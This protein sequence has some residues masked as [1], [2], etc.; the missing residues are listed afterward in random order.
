MAIFNT[1]SLRKFAGIFLVFSLVGVFL[2][3]YFLKYIPLEEINFHHSSFLELKQFESALEERNNAYAK[4]IENFIQYRD[5]STLHGLHSRDSVDLTAIAKRFNYR[6][7]QNKPTPVFYVG[8][9]SLLKLHKISLKRDKLINKWEIE[10]TVCDQDGEPVAGF[11]KNVDTLV[12]GLVASYR[13]IFDDYLIIRDNHLRKKDAEE[14]ANSSEFPDS[15]DHLHDG[16]II[17]NSGNLSVDYLVNTDSLLKKN[18]GF[19]LL[20][21]HDVIIE[22]NAYKLFLYPIRLGKERL[23]LGGLI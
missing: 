23:I 2:S 10:Y 20:N 17:F 9:D 15:T 21:I 1:P 12:S 11:R 13:D 7:Y 16:E 8:K 5:T 19:S 4:S 6:D 18:D 22:G 3:L 14:K